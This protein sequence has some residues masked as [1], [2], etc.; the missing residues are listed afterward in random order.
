MVQ[1]QQTNKKRARV[2]TLHTQHCTTTELLRRL[3]TTLH[4]HHVACRTDVRQSECG[5]GC[6]MLEAR[7]R[8]Q[9]RR[10]RKGNTTCTPRNGVRMSDKETEEGPPLRPATLAGASL[11]VGDGRAGRLFVREYGVKDG[12]GGGWRVESPRSSMRP[13]GSQGFPYGQANRWPQ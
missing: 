7:R 3:S 5:E 12:F 9:T 1:K 6:S 13:V 8:M 10:R 11:H 4:I 2:L